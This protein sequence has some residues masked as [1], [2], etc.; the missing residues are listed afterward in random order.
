[1][2]GI[3]PAMCLLLIGPLAYS[4][5]LSWFTSKVSSAVNYRGIEAAT[6]YSVPGSHPPMPHGARITQVHA[7]R[8]Y[9][10]D[11]RVNTLLCWNGTERCVPL[12]GSQV[13]THEFDGLAADK[14]LTL[15]HQVPGRGRLPIPL[16][17]KGSV[18][19]WYE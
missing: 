18:A 15:L 1:M 9:A 16:H 2:R 12:T 17:I 6:V 14:P 19:V 10:G 5:E 3:A 13:N 7:S 4:G 11:V 8:S